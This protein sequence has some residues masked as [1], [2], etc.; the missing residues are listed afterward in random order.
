LKK[1]LLVSIAITF[2]VLIIG[3]ILLHFE[4]IGY[5][6]AFF[7]WLP[8]LLGYFFGKATLKSASLIGLF[9]GLIMFLIIIYSWGVEGIICVAMAFPLLTLSAGVGALLRQAVLRIKKD[10]DEEPN[11]KSSLIPILI[12]SLVAIVENQVHQDA[13]VEE[14][15]TEI[16]LPYTCLEV[17]NSIK[18]V[19]TL[20]AELPF[21]MKIDLP[22]PYKCIL[23]EERVGGLRT[24]YFEGGQIVERITELKEGEILRMD[25]IDYQLTGRK[26]LGFEEAIYTFEETDDGKCKMIRTTTYTSELYPRFYWRPLENWGIQEEHEYVFNNLK[27]DLGGRN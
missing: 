6:W 18:N 7:F 3:F 26:W 11:L 12:F 25:V 15:Q 5:G 21:L 22:I 27:L 16:I 4:L 19:D 13:I 24:C 1:E 23:E 17:Y 14:V 9:L 10:K 20:D 8:A 2:I